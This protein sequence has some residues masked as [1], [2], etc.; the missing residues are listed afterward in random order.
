MKRGFTLIETL[1][2]V[3]LTVAAFITLT[4]LLFTFNS[5]NEYQQI[6]IQ[7][8]GSAGTAI[9]DLEA[10]ILPADHVLTSHVFSG[11][12][13][14]SGTTTLILQLPAVDTSGNSI[15]GVSDYVGFYV[16]SSSLYRVIAAN[17]ASSRSSGVKLLSST[18][19]SLLF[20]YNT[21]TFDEVTNIIVDIR[22]R[23]TFKQQ[24]VSS[25]LY[26]QWYLRNHP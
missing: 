24:L 16:S 9:N 8:A 22:T 14:S 23:A 13:L 15:P 21:S 18:L 7:T 11:I 5:L 12:S 26:G 1:V 3:A 17:A 2:V 25:T 6:S 10:A 19:D 4:N 20:T